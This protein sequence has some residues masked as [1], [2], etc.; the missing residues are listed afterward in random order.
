MSKKIF[1]TGGAGYIG[2]HTVLY[3]L[4]NGYEVIV[5]DNLE[6]GNKAALDKIENLTGKKIQ[7][8]VGDLKNPEDIRNAVNNNEFDGVIH[9]AAHMTVLESVKDP[10]KYFWN[11]IIGSQNLIDALKEKGVSNLIFSSTSEVYGEAP[12]YPVLEDMP[13]IPENMYGESKRMTEVMLEN[14]SR[15]FGFKYVILR[16]FNAAGADLEGRIGEAHHPEMHLIPNAL[17]GALGIKK[18]ELTSSK[19]DTPDGTTIRDYVH[20]VDLASAHT[21]ALEYLWDGGKSDVFNTGTGK[22]SSVMEII[23]AVEKVTGKKIEVTEGEPR[24]GEPAKKYA[25]ADKIEEVLGW[26]A[27]YGIDE[28]VASAY[29]WHLNSPQGY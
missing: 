19:V 11:N 24:P 12:S 7:L 23:K 27:Q 10:G 28:I 6:D 15:E 5:F 25:N 26:K 18:F 9:F 29:K 22:G 20:V 13:R 4:E 14:Y 3:L 8:I 21:K 1:I 2:S 16:Y 17:M